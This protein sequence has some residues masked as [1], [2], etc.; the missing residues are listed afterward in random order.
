MDNAVDSAM[1]N[2]VDSSMDNAVDSSMDN[3]VDSSMDNAVDS[4][5]RCVCRARSAFVP[6]DESLSIYSSELFSLIYLY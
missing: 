2:A 4:A 6:C 1:D 3:A 5:M